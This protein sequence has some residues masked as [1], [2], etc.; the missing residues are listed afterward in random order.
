MKRSRSS[1][2]SV[3]VL[4]LTLGPVGSWL[5]WASLTEPSTTISRV[6]R[7][8]VPS[9]LGVS[10]ARTRSAAESLRLERVRIA[11]ARAAFDQAVKNDRFNPQTFVVSLSTPMLT[12]DVLSAVTGSGAELVQLHVWVQPQDGSE[13]ITTGH[14]A[15]GPVGFIVGDQGQ[16]AVKS[17]TDMYVN[18]IEGEVLELEGRSRIGADANALGKLRDRAVALRLARERIERDGVSLYGW[19]CSC[20]PDQILSI[21]AQLST[22]FRAIEPKSRQAL[23]IWPEDPVRARLLGDGR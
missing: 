6:D 23:P 17:L 5:A 10:A 4:L 8:P 16:S 19:E 21:E 14:H 18:Y 20:S 15:A 1:A 11:E 12:R 2:V 3:V 7:E 9:D 13:Q 22:T